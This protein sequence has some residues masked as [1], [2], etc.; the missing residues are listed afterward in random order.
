MKKTKKLLE[1][2]GKT[3][4]RSINQAPA[5]TIKR[6]KSLAEQIY[7]RLRRDIITGVLM[8]DERIIELDIAEMMGTSQGP[9]REALQRLERDGLVSK[10]AR[11][12]TRVTSAARDEIL[13]L[14]T[15]RSLIESF[16][17]KR[18]SPRI[19]AEQ[20]RELEFLVEMMHIAGV[21]EDMFALTES[22]MLFH[23]QL[24]VWS[25]NSALY[26]AWDPLYGQIQRFVVQTHND[27]FDS[28]T[29][30][31]ATHYPIIAA[32]K[33]GQADEASRIIQ[34]HVM[35]IWSKLEREK[36]D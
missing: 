5:P 31:A 6:V 17:V 32:L 30:L 29:N 26:R 16:A 9:V 35:L 24:C 25:G 15:I 14:F 2:F 20:I 3:E 33:S 11:S 23:R 27:Y 28:L 13:E 21:Q 7:E 10:Q 12:A 34:D 36:E 1:L 8:P 19:T 4:A 18:V 22:D